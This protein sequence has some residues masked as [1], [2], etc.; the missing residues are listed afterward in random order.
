VQIAERGSESLHD[1]CSNAKFQGAQTLK[2]S[3]RGLAFQKGD[4]F[5]ADLQQPTLQYNVLANPA[6][7]VHYSGT[8]LSTIV[9]EGR[10]TLGY[11]L[12]VQAQPTI[13]GIEELLSKEM[14]SFTK[15]LA[16]NTTLD[17]KF[18]QNGHRHF[19]MGTPNPY[20]EY[21][22]EFFKYQEDVVLSCSGK[23][24]ELQSLLSPHR[25]ILQTDMTA[26]KKKVW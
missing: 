2:L 15:I 24:K 23:A 17:T 5:C 22:Q 6:L 19:A 26:D 7:A 12:L 21:L 9:Q 1:F 18:F 4:G 13:G 10:Q 14:R 25:P 8:Q 16:T 11:P 20:R 3:I